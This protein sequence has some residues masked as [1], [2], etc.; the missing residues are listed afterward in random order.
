MADRMKYA[1]KCKY[2]GKDFH[3]HRRRQLF[4]SR[5]CSV[6]GRKGGLRRQDR[7]DCVCEQC[8]KPIKKRSY[9][10]GKSERHFCGR[11]CLYESHRV[12][13][14]GANNP[15]YQAVPLKKC[16][17]C[18]KEYRSY[19]STRRYCSN[20]CSQGAS[21]SQALASARRGALAE[22]RCCEDLKRSGYTAFRSAGSR[23]P[24]DV[25]GVS[26]SEFLLVQVKC[27]KSL[28]K[29]RIFMRKDV[30]KL[31]KA[32]YPAGPV[33]RRQIWCWVEPLEEWRV[34][35]LSADDP[36]YGLS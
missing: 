18:G 12:L 24:F 33:A 4:C 29:G 34:L 15:N 19:D 17:A 28:Q 32:V 13:Y 16:V 8:G 6:R 14:A 27:T 1:L 21:A 7:V 22:R 25:I 5:E 10:H 9:H 26:G 35:D 11:R 23:G 31:K 30:E 2:C 3:P 36:F 20:L